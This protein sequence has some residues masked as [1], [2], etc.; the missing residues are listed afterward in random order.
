[1]KKNLNF[2]YI[3]AILLENIIDPLGKKMKKNTQKSISMRIPRGIHSEI[4]K[5]AKRRNISITRLV[6]R[7]LVD[8]LNQERLLEK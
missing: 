1:M 8:T 2:V 4:K 6:L 5:I 7:L 3:V